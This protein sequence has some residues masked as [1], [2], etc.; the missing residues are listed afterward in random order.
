MENFVTCY[1]QYHLGTSVSDDTIGAEVTKET[2]IIIVNYEIYQM[3][4]NLQYTKYK[5]TMTQIACD[6][7]RVTHADR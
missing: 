7:H 4:D 1:H 5:R 3:T 2:C 6:K